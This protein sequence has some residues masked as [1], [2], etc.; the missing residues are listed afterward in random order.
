MPGRSYRNIKMIFISLLILSGL[1]VSVFSQDVKIGGI[2]NGYKHVTMVGPGTDNVTLNNIDGITSGDTVLLIQMQGVGISTSDGIYGQGVIDT[3]G[4]PGGYE[5]L[6]VGAVDNGTKKVFFTRNILNSFDVRGNVQLIQVPCYTAATVT[7]TVT[8]KSW[9]DTDKTGGVVAMIVGGKLR[10]DADIDVSGQGFK[11][12]KDTIGI[13]ECVMVNQTANSHDSYPRTW[14]NAGYKGEGIANYDE[15]RNL[16]YPLHAKGQGINLTGGG[17]GNGKYSG[18]GGGSNRGKGGDGTYEK[19][20]GVGSC[21]DFQ[22]GAFGGTTV[23][24]SVIENDFFMGGGGG[25]STHALGSS[26]SSGGNGGGIIIIIADT[27]SGNGHFLKADGQ[28]AANADGDGGAGGG[29]AGGSVI[30]TLQSFSSDPADLLTVS[31][32]GGNGG[33]NPAGYGNGG[34]GGGGLVWLSTPTKPA[35]VSVDYNY[36]SPGTTDGNGDI[37]Y[38]FIP[39]LNGFLFNTIRSSVTGN[40]VDSICSNVP[41]GQIT[42]T[43]PVGGTSPYTFQWERSILPDTTN[44]SPAAGINNQ[45]NYSPGLLS[46]TTWFRRTVTDQGTPVITD[47]SNPV[48]I[49]VQQAITGNLVGNDAT[50][51]YNQVPVSLV[52][53][54][55][56]PANGSSYNY[57]YYKWIQNNT[58]ANWD[59]SPDASGINNSPSGSYDPPALTDTTYYQ[60]VVTSGRCIDYSPTVTITVLPLITGNITTRSDSVICEGAQFVPLSAS[61]AGGGNATYL[62]QWQDSAASSVSFLPAAGVNTG[63]TYLPD[64]STFAVTEQRFLRRVVFSGPLNVC[65]SQSEPILLTRYHKIINNSILAD[66]TICSGDTPL[67]LTGLTPAQGKA[68]EYTYVWQDSIRQGVWTTRATTPLTFSPPALTDSTWYRRIVYSGVYKS[69]PVCTSTSPLLRIAVHK[70][71]E[72]NNISLI[73]GNFSDTT[74]CNG[75]IPHQLLGTVPTGG[76]DLPGDYIYQWKYSTDNSI[77]IPVPSGGIGA[78][79]QPLSLTATTY[80]K[81]EVTSGTC[82]GESNVITVNVLPSITGNTISANQT[83]CYNT[84]PA[85]LTS[86][87]ILGGGNGAG[88][89][90]FYWEQSL[91]NGITWTAASGTNNSPAGEYSPPVLTVPVKYRRTATSGANGCCTSV[92]NVIDISI[93]P[94]LPTGTITSTADTTI[95]E[96]SKVRLNIHLTGQTKWN[97]RY[98]ENS[99]LSNPVS[100]AATDT[101]L[102]VSPVTGTALTIFNYSLES[103]VDRNGCNAVVLDG[104]RKATVYKV[105]VADAGIDRSVCGPVVNL[106]ATPSVGTGAWYYP[107]AVIASTIN[108]P[109][110]IT[111]TIDSTFSGGDIS[112]KFYWEEINWQCRNKD[113]VTITFDKRVSSVD[114]G[115]DTSIY[116]FD[117]TIQMSAGPLLSWQTGL[118]TVES[119]SGIINPATGNHAEVS[120]LATGQNIFLWTVTNGECHN[121]DQVNILVH[122]EFI[123]KGFSPNDD[124]IND[125]FIIEGLTP[126]LEAEFRVVNG[127]GTE[128]FSTGNLN[129]QVWKDWDG[130]NS[131]GA[132]LPEGTYYYL[133]KVTSKITGQVFK[134]SGFIMLKRY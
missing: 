1:T 12:G 17:G 50:I 120:N 117:N 78:S 119:G 104:S 23:L 93:Y 14:L 112:H 73:S 82:P 88:S 54:N 76:T 71:I 67:P 4:K 96:G 90:T 122:N 43:V 26:G 125:T 69:L 44:F 45:Q 99:V 77:F 30:L 74:I 116:S 85:Q 20:L 108:S 91:N 107:S 11:G 21:P 18:G 55:A 39:K 61:A 72:N 36:G 118:W 133:L 28:T 63:I 33:I 27:I 87:D 102:L 2:I 52:P 35:K 32:K 103:V 53:L 59:T 24:A 16:L 9:D 57:Y 130:K 37:R 13:G 94:P 31:V 40:Q 15:L 46:Q 101:T 29:G 7:A 113:S 3:I 86:A 89:Y 105:P 79:Y 98:L 41:F 100:I 95:C 129:G 124:Q 84:S 131:N 70:P 127:A 60:R 115:A 5:F 123:P 34:G 49:I 62:Y 42:G 66:Q 126:D 6:L 111:V 134:R 58:N 47:I 132:G 110:S 97:V 81:R 64:T 121:Q 51:C 92:S 128:V 65:K 114:A 22:P 25:S 109:S 19:N 106:A 48:K 83:V 38:N 80:F 68:G 8:S 56:G 75:Q 10:L